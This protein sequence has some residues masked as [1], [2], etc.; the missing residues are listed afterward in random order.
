MF[1]ST[2]QLKTWNI[3]YICINENIS[4]VIHPRPDFLLADLNYKACFRV[5]VLS[6]WTRKEKL[7]DPSFIMTFRFLL[8][9][10]TSHHVF[11]AP[12]RAS[13]IEFDLLGNLCLGS[14]YK[15]WKAL[16]SWICKVGMMDRY[17]FHQ[18]WEG[19]MF[20]HVKIMGGKK[21]GRRRGRRST[22]GNK[23]AVTERGMKIHRWLKRT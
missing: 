20:I 12:R 13:L 2:I 11:R 21:G 10:S 14:L 3:W 17:R 22:R 7:L 5:L 9:Y 16:W 8:C 4:K 15:I 1:P 19:V 23:R 18:W 6:A